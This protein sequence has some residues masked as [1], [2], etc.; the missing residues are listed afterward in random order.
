MRLLSLNHIGVRATNRQRSE[1]FYIGVLGLVQHPTKTNWLRTLDGE[2]SVHLMPGTD[3]SNDGND[4]ADLA[5][6]V[7]LETD[8]LEAVV[9]E[10]LAQGLKPFQGDITATKRKPLTDSSDLTFGIGTVFVFDPDMN[11]V[12]FIDRRRGIF[13]QTLGLPEREHQEPG[14]APELGG[15]SG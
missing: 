15:A 7:A 6:H 3:G 4:N 11:L 13:L 1:D 8:D 12:E 10:L 14:V 2:F 5:R 9:D